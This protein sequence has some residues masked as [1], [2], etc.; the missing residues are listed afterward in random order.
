MPRSQPQKNTKKRSMSKKRDRRST[1]RRNP[2]VQ[3]Y[4][5]WWRNKWLTA[6]AKTMGDM[7]KEL[8]GAAAYLEELKNAGVVLEPEGC[9]DDYAHFVTTDPRVARKFRFEKEVIE[10]CC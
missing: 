5:M 10:E 1:T 8:R 6:D 7:V 2:E 3:R 4:T 9:P